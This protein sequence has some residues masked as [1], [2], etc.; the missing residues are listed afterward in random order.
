MKI[1]T[2]DKQTLIKFVC[3]TKDGKYAKINEDSIKY[4]RMD[5]KTEE[6]YETEYYY[7]IR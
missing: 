4:S 2:K 6:N 7:G 1:L 5:E 3:E